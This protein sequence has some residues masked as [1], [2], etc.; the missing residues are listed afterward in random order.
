MKGKP[1]RDPLVKAAY[2][3]LRH[4]PTESIKRTL[5][6]Y[7]HLHDMADTEQIRAQIEACKLLLRPG[8]KL[9]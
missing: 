9:D 2:D 5:T 7:R 1:I 6:Y 8:G 4:Q 3:H